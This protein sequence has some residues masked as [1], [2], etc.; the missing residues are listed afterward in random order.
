MNYKRVYYKPEDE[1]ILCQFYVQM[2]ADCDCNHS[3]IVW[4]WLRNSPWFEKFQLDKSGIWKE[5]DEIEI[6]MLKREDERR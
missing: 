4:E 6:C 2:N 5:N 1:K 3:R